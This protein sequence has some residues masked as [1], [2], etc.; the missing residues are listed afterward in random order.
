MLG[1]ESGLLVGV[2]LTQFSR[3][4]DLAAQALLD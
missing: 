2:G 4:E 3:P 1:S